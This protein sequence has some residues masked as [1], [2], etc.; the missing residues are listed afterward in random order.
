MK[1]FV[2][3]RADVSSGKYFFEMAKELRVDR[4]HIFEMPV[5]SAVFNHQNLAVAFENRGLNL[6][7]PLIH[8][9]AQILPAIQNLATR[10]AHTDWT[11]R[12]CLSRPTER[13]LGLFPRFQ[14]RSIGPSWS[15]GFLCA[16]PVDPLEHEPGAISGK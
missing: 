3:M 14:E 11:K 5:R 12:I 8:E 16:E 1:F 7:E 10:L 4:D 15:K 6:S 2:A 9:N 13:R